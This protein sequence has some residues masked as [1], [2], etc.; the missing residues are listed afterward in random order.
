M[1]EQTLSRKRK[2]LALME[3]VP[4]TQAELA[5]RVGV[6]P[7]AVQGW[8]KKGHMARNTLVKVAK[9]LRCEESEILAILENEQRNGTG[10]FSLEEIRPETRDEIA[11]YS[12]PPVLRDQITRLID[13]ITDGAD[14][15]E[16]ED[17]DVEAIFALVTRLRRRKH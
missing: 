16:L 1:G 2:F 3:A 10:L 6:K 5:R 14:A 4:I 7:Q 13:T 17:D 15:G 11:V 12:R 9:A 8:I